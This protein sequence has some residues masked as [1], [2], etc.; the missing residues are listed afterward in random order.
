M[1]GQDSA[2]LVAVM[3]I[4]GRIGTRRSQAQAVGDVSQA[5][6]TGINKHAPRADPRKSSAMSGWFTRS[7]ADPAQAGGAS[8]KQA[9]VSA[10]GPDIAGAAA[11]AGVWDQGLGPMNE[12]AGMQ[13]LMLWTEMDSLSCC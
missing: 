11:E 6:A 9:D 3:G 1:S 10:W 7:Q 4:C 12:T 13:C 2:H 8:S 5:P